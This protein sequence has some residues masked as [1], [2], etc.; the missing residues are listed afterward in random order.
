MDGNA[1]ISKLGKLSPSSIK[2]NNNSVDEFHCAQVSPTYLGLDRSHFRL[3]SSYQQRERDARSPSWEDMMK[4]TFLL[5]VLCFMMIAPL[6]AQDKITREGCEFKGSM[7]SD[8]VFQIAGKGV[9]S[10]AILLSATV[11]VDCDAGLYHEQCFHRDCAKAIEFHV[12]YTALKKTEVRFTI[13]WIG[14][15]CASHVSPW[16]EIPKLEYYYAYFYTDQKFK[17]GLYRLVVTAE[18]KDIASGAEGIVDC[19]FQVW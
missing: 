8:D 18:Q 15:E 14:P 10:K 11:W 12:D 17:K 13:T 4:Q 7:T 9:T 16:Y 19:L 5:F 3:Y 1:N 2:A 6:G